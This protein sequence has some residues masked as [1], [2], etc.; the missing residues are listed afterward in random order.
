M[1][2]EHRVHPGVQPA[3]EASVALASPASAPG[4]ASTPT[5][6][7]PTSPAE[8]TVASFTPES[9]ASGPEAVS[10]DVSSSANATSPPDSKVASA[11]LDSPHV[12]PLHARPL[13]HFS[14]LQHGS[15]EPPQL[16][17]PSWLPASLP[18]EPLKALIEP[19]QLATTP[20]AITNATTPA[21]VC[22]KVDAPHGSRAPLRIG[23]KERVRG[24]APRGPRRLSGGRASTHARRG[25]ALVVLRVD[26]RHL[27][28]SFGPPGCTRRG[29][30]AGATRDYA[31][32]ALSP[33]SAAPSVLDA[34]IAAYQG[35]SRAAVCA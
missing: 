20:A 19:P 31:A 24:S 3:S 22:F 28:R 35:S 26:G 5:S 27:L 4:E 9:P 14:P 29:A 10:E 18:G 32:G 7:T 34:A 12:P 8:S 1:L 30:V 11:W 6:A 16:G 17:D 23:G 2:P 13:P 33:L 15:P 21:S 25:W